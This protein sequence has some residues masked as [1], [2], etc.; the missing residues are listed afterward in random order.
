M[1]F[2]LI[3]LGFTNII[4]LDFAEDVQIEPDLS[5]ELVSAM[6]DFGLETNDFDDGEE[7]ELGSI[8]TGLILK[9]EGKKL[10]LLGDNSPYNL[11]GAGAS[12]ERM[13]N[14]DLVA[15]PYNGYADDYP[16]C[17]TNW[18][19]NKRKDISYAQ[20]ENRWAQQFETLRKLQPKAVLPYSSDFALQGPLA[21]EFV[22]VHSP[23]WTN[24]HYVS[25]YVEKHLGCQ[26]FALFEGDVASLTG[27]KC[28]DVSRKQDPLSRMRLSD[29]AEYT[30]SPISNTKYL[31][32]NI[33]SVDALEYSM[34]QASE[35]MANIMEGRNVSSN[36]QLQITMTDLEDV[37]FVLDFDSGKVRRGKLNCASD[38]WICYLDSNYLNAILDFKSHWDDARISF[39]LSWARD[40]NFYDKQAYMALNFFHQRT[41]N[42]KPYI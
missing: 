18:D 1:R 15:V 29:F 33:E 12:V 6:N 26:S 39:N 24:K 31:F 32:E 37:H 17:Y 4:S 38:E 42:P 2:T 34:A 16:V 36:A 14:C 21:K 25:A 7:I 11:D 10:L 5:V 35:H 30:Y 3:E 20:S 22:N 9:A 13:M 41:R 8:D 23:D 19:L 40:E 28:W 27:A